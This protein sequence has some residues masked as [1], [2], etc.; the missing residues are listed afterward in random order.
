VAALG[1]EALLAGATAGAGGAALGLLRQGVSQQALQPGEAVR[2]AFISGIT[3]GST[4][5]STSAQSPNA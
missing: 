2:A 1:V 3:N 4:C 5:P